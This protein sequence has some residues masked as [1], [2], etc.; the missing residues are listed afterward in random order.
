MFSRDYNAAVRRG[1]ERVLRHLRVGV[2]ARVRRRHCLVR[3]LHVDA[4]VVIWGH[5]NAARPER[6]GCLSLYRLAGNKAPLPSGLFAETKCRVRS[7]QP[8]TGVL[9]PAPPTRFAPPLR[10][11]CLGL[12]GWQQR[13]DRGRQRLVVPCPLPSAPQGRTPR[14]QPQ[15]SCTRG[16]R[17]GASCTFSSSSCLALCRTA[18]PFRKR[19]RCRGN[20]GACRVYPLYHE[21][22]SL[23]FHFSLGLSS[24]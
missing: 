17:P 5:R 13:N 14:P 9:V 8:S 11:C 23:S 10:A 18:G 12:S 3:L 24:H 16:P 22:I 7:E 15:L 20:H 19:I 6:R 4:I 21:Q 2:R 1:G